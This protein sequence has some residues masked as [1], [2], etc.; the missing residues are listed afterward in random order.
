MAKELKISSRALLSIYAAVPLGILVIAIDLFMLDRRIVSSLPRDPEEL[1]LVTIF[2]VLPHIVASALSFLDSEYLASYKKRLLACI[3]VIGL[4]V[5]GLPLLVGDIGATL[6]YA[7]YTV[8]HVMM[9]Q[10]GITSL[11]YGPPD[12]KFKLWKWLTI[13]SS[14]LLFLMIHLGF[15]MWGEVYLGY[16][17]YNLF[18]WTLLGMLA[19]MV[20]LGIKLSPNSQHTSGS[21]YLW[22]NTIMVILILPL[23]QL[24][25]YFFAILIPRL[26]HELTAFV[27]YIAHDT[28]RN[29][30]K[31][32]NIVYRALKFS[33]IPIF[34]LCP[35]VA[36][37][38]ANA[39]VEAQHIEWVKNGIFAL[40]YFHYFTEG[41]IWKRDSPH[42]QAI[43]LNFN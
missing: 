41:T 7:T 16:T 8:Y 22:A 17:Y 9:Q 35:I 5:W 25:Y 37:V 42:R 26:V 24:E 40:I 31:P 20:V 27:F 18:N 33:R 19:A 28:N 6:V 39:L 13:I 30:D 3:P 14:T 15:A 4:L 12:L 11:L 23:Y 34:I 2:L 1:R 32:S 43:K 21:Q 38:L 10:V 29:K 36:I